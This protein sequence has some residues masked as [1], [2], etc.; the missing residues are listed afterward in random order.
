MRLSI[1]SKIFVGFLVVL[2]TSGAVSLFAVLRVRRIGYGL[3]LISSGYFPLTREASSLEAFQKERERSTIHLLDEK[4]PQARHQLI[5]LDHTYFARV[6][7]EK[8]ARART[9]VQTAVRAPSSNDSDAD[10]LARIELRFTSLSE[11]I[12]QE[13]SNRELLAK[14]LAQRDAT[15]AH[16]AASC[17]PAIAPREMAELREQIERLH[18]SERRVDYEL[19]TLLDG[20]QMQMNRGVAEAQAQERETRTMLAVLAYFW[21]SWARN[22]PRAHFKV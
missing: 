9:L 6:V 3:S 20:L 15:C 8:L 1:A 14:L 4:D 10:S 19:K 18:A 12:A 21:G 7:G 22:G 5:D 13:E 11:Q 17:T 2:V 16:D